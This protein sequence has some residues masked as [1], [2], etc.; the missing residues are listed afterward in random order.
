MSPARADRLAV[1][2]AAAGSFL[3]YLVSAAPG[4]YWLDSSE[5]AAAGFGLG[6]AHPPGHPLWAMLAKALALVPIGPVAFRINMLSA[7][8]GAASCG[9]TAAIALRLVRARHPDARMASALAAAGALL[10]GASSAMWLQ[11]VRAEVY[12]PHTAAMLLVLWLGV[13]WGLANEEGDSERWRGPAPIALASLVLG[14][15]LASH[16]YLVLFVLPALLLLLLTDPRG[17]ALVRSRRAW[18]LVAP[19][20][21]GLLA[22]AYLPV[23]AAQDPAVCWVGPTTFGRFWD[24]VSA[25]TFQ[26]SVTQTVDNDVLANLGA[27]LLLLMTELHPMVVVLGLGGLGAVTLRWGPRWGGFLGV[28]LLGNLL[29]TAIM[30]FDPSNPDAHGYL[31]LAHAIIVILAVALTARVA[32]GLA[33]SG[34]R[35]AA[36]A[37]GGSLLLSAVAGLGRQLEQH[38]PRSDLRA[39]TATE[40]IEDAELA[41]APPGALVLPSYYSLLFQHWY[42]QQVDGR[43]PDVTVVQQSFDAKIHEGVPYTEALL[44]HHPHYHAI[45]EAW[46]RDRQ[47]PWREL[48][49]ASERDPVLV[50]PELALPVPTDRLR[51]LGLLAAVVPAGA[52]TEPPGD[53]GAQWDALG[54]RLLDTGGLARETREALLWSHFRA[55]TVYLRQQHV[56]AAADA[57]ARAQAL[58]ASSAAVQRLALLVKRMAASSPSQRKQMAAE[59]DG[60]DLGALISP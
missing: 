54:R 4:T 19:A 32:D 9:L 35:V 60:S 25:R 48:L 59:L 47:T 28:A 57:V 15:S 21:A 53:L 24:V 11:S 42:A 31:E 14:L 44:R 33:A 36:T 16:H 50:E 20:A 6:V 2:A 58:G 13:R 26:A 18:L 56:A 45:F 38:G 8:G 27:E 29:S 46:L 7:L 22:Y 52:P 41:L 23:R 37:V 51:G 39:F 3:L 40:R 1:L 5:L 34:R 55:A 30:R 17:R 12:T 43:R 49:A 10:L